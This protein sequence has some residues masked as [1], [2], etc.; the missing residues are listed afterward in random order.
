MLHQTRQAGAC[1][2]DRRARTLGFGPV[3]AIAFDIAVRVHVPVLSVF[4]VTIHGERNSVIEGTKTVTAPNGPTKAGRQLV[5]VGV[6]EGLIVEEL[7]GPSTG[8]NSYV[9]RMGV[10]CHPLRV[11]IPPDSIST[12]PYMAGLKDRQNGSG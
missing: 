1:D 12:A 8:S 4:T 11:L 5:F 7:G 9:P 6:P 3:V 10:I 2:I